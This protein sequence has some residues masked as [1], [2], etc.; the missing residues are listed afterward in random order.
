[1]KERSI[2]STRGRGWV[3]RKWMTV[4]CGVGKIGGSGGLESNGQNQQIY[5]LNQQLLG[6]AHCLDTCTVAL[7]IYIRSPTPNPPIC[8]YFFNKAVLKSVLPRFDTSRRAFYKPY[9]ILPVENFHL[10]S[11]Y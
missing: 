5:P 11:N 6:I 3:S 7:Y 8:F 2:N 1:M 4:G 10:F 9:N